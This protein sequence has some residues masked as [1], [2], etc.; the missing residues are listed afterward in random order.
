VKWQ[1]K[2]VE[3]YDLWWSPNTEKSV[4]FWCRETLHAI[5]HQ[6]KVDKSVRIVELCSGT[7]RI[8]IPV[9]RH[10]LDQ[11]PDFHIEAICLDYSA[12]MNA[13]LLQK[14][15]AD[16]QLASAISVREFDIGEENWAPAL[17]EATVN[18][19]LFPLNHFAQMG[20]PVIQENVIKNVSKHLAPGGSLED[21][22]PQGSRQRDTGKKQFRWMVAD[23][24]NNRALYYWRQS[25][26]LE[27]THRYAQVLY[28]IELVEWDDSGLRWE[29]LTVTERIYYNSPEEL[30]A[31]LS[32]Y[33][34][35]VESRYGD[36]TGA[37][38]TEQSLTQLVIAKK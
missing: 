37:P 34:L 16:E 13:A 3:V 11:L 9:I 15:H 20:D 25:W 38:F 4:P 8:L 26:P 5:Q 6:Q 23:T 18:V 1:G 36:Y 31:L 24:S 35:R 17:G 33:G 32:R 19:F 28:A 2:I 14:L 22:N 29:T 30:D 12:E 27:R 21:Y 7:G 10:L